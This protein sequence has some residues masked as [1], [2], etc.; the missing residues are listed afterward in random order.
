MKEK[1]GKWQRNPEDPTG[2]NRGNRVTSMRREPLM[3][4][5]GHGFHGAE[6]RVSR[7]SFRSLFGGLRL[8]RIDG[9]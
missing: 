9:R 7:R 4:T 2:E 8:R 1:T 6:K 3:N 5:D